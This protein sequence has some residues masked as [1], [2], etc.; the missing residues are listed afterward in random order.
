VRQPAATGGAHRG[1]CSSPTEALALIEKQRYDAIVS[2]FC[3]PDLSGLA[4]LQAA[5]AIDATVPFVLMTG[6][7]SIES[8]ISAIDLG[9]HKYLP[10]PFDVD[11]FVE[12]VAD[13][14]KRRVGS[15]DLSSLHRRLDRALEGLWMAYQPI[16]EFSRQRPLAYE[17]LLRTTATEVKGPPTCSC[18][19]RRRAGCS[20]SVA[21]SASQSRWSCRVSRSMSTCS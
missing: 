15:E 2:D 19:P 1:A 4:L 10:K 18:W 7:P 11:V 14:V 17:A 5:R 21:R 8:A 6:A 3:M 16:V 12:T 20:I 13:A 9:V